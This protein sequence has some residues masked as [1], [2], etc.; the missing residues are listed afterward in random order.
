MRDF[1]SF[2]DSAGSLLQRMG[3]SSSL[4]VHR[5]SCLEAVGP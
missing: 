5:L 3:F 2:F 4:V 1:F